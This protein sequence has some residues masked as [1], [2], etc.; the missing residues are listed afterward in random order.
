MQSTQITSLHRILPKA[1]QAVLVAV[2]ILF[3]VMAPLQ[4]ETAD[5]QATSLNPIAHVKFASAYRP[6]HHWLYFR[7]SHADWF[8][9]TTLVRTEADYQLAWPEL[10]TRQPLAQALLPYR[11]PLQYSII[12]TDDRQPAML[13]DGSETIQPDQGREYRIQAKVLDYKKPVVYRQLLAAQAGFD[14]I[15]AEGDTQQPSANPAY[16]Q[17]AEHAIAAYAID[18]S[19]IRSDYLKAVAISRWLTEN[20]S[21]MFSQP[22]RSKAYIAMAPRH[23]RFA[24]IAALAIRSLGFP[25][26]VAYG[27]AVPRPPIDSQAALIIHADNS[28]AW[29]EIHIQGF[30]WIPV[31]VC[32]APLYDKRDFVPC[33]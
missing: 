11:I 31:D 21:A 3:A 13:L 24:Q 5:N 32:A 10:E 1:C 22:S 9:G 25:A 15:D 8:D 18:D 29:P 2:G 33:Y 19:G 6:V 20:G 7:Q 26:R 14:R 4:A 30:G 17:L 28:R 12:A 23:D 16:R 27:Y